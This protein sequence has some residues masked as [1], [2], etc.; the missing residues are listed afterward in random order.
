MLNDIQEVADESFIAMMPTR[1]R[2]DDL[3]GLTGA[4]ENQ[5]APFAMRIESEAAFG[6]ED[7]QQGSRAATA[8]GMAG[9]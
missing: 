7:R 2:V 4:E 1:L 8:G 5:T 6:A 3:F 9:E